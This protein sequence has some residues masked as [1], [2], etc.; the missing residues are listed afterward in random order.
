MSQVSP[1]GMFNWNMAE[2]GRVHLR[3]ETP[4]QSLRW[5]EAET[6]G[7]IVGRNL[8]E[9]KIKG[10]LNNQNLV[11][12][13]GYLN[14][15]GRPAVTLEIST[16]FQ[17]YESID[18]KISSN[19]FNGIGIGRSIH[20]ELEKSDWESKIKLDADY[21]Y[22]FQG[23]LDMEAELN[24]VLISFMDIPPL[25]LQ[26]KSGTEQSNLTGVLKG[27]LGSYNVSLQL[28]ALMEETGLSA[29]LDGKAGDEETYNLHAELQFHRTENFFSFRKQILFQDK[30]ILS[31]VMS[32]S[33]EVEIAGGDIKI[34][35]PWGPLETN[36]ALIPVS[37]FM[38]ESEISFDKLLYSTN[39]T[40]N[41]SFN[42]QRLIG[43]QFAVRE[44]KPILEIYNPIS[45]ISLMLSFDQPQ[46]NSVKLRGEFCWNIYD[47]I[48]NTVGVTFHKVVSYYGSDFSVQIHAGTVGLAE[49]KLFHATN[50]KGLNSSLAIEW[51]SPYFQTQGMT[52]YSVSFAKDSTPNHN[53]YDGFAQVDLPWRSIVVETYNNRS[54]KES[55][56]SFIIKWDARN[57][58][59][60]MISVRSH[61]EMKMT[62]RVIEAS[63]YLVIKHPLSE[64][65]LI[66]SID[67]IYK[68][69]RFQHVEVD[70]K[71]SDDPEG[72][73]MFVISRNK[74][75]WNNFRI[76]GRHTPSNL[77]TEVSVKLTD[78]NVSVDLRY[79]DL[80]ARTRQA[81]FMGSFIPGQY[82]VELL[83]GDEGHQINLC[84]LKTQLNQD[85]MI[86]SL[87][88]VDTEA[89][90]KI[91]QSPPYFETFINQNNEESKIKFAGGFLHKKEL[92][93]QLSKTSL[94]NE[95]NFVLATM[96]LNSNNTLSARV[97]WDPDTFSN[98]SELDLSKTLNFLIVDFKAEDVSKILASEIE[99][100][101]K[102]VS[103]ELIH[104]IQEVQRI[105]ADESAAIFQELMVRYNTLWELYESNF[106]Y[107]QDICTYVSFPVNG[108]RKMG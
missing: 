44:G 96:R 62:W 21:R 81:Q 13:F 75:D 67:Q 2:A 33:P 61:D 64:L 37:A 48:G 77:Y 30:S 7:K 29:S 49:L 98:L 22:L 42:S 38:G 106:L 43:A 41:L 47:P 63:R 55:Q 56:S 6:A 74:T 18:F 25:H 45:P 5:F 73:F 14:E 46:S 91:H 23:F 100:R 57:D 68:D 15:D 39:I 51:N 10:S 107:I 24:G 40:Y 88:S 26:F 32:F 50:H 108:I 76:M 92:R 95:V 4:M 16:P 69:N 102:S 59:S 70:F 90:V 27:H 93:L 9:M 94:D 54:I 103:P 8:I 31:V 65:P 71:T 72:N 1:F 99:G 105:I 20:M 53:S 87:T 35:T 85:P 79:M 66:L 19:K 101:W 17:H 83:G 84:S 12:N 36:L 97:Y 52:G 80:Q 86:V 104:A 28:E 78:H 60:K 89:E 82:S 58:E 11:T 3:I 34:S